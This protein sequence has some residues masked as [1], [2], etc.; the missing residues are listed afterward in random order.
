MPANANIKKNDSCVATC[1][2]AP[3]SWLDPHDAF[4]QKKGVTPEDSVNATQM[5]K[6]SKS[7]KQIL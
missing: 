4:L 6:P 5:Y 7:K 3:A 1:S 2:A